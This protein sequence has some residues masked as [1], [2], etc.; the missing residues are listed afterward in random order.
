MPASCHVDTFVLDNLPPAAEQPDFIN[1][2]RLG[3]PEQL[4]LSTAMS[5]KAAASGSPYARRA[6]AGPMPNSPGP[7]TGWPMS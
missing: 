6:C 2:D 4:N 3:Y 7:S 1:L 5:P